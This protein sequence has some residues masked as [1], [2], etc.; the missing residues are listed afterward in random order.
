LIDFGITKR[1]RDPI[2]GE[3]ISFKKN[4]GFM[5]TLRFSSINATR[6]HEQSRRDDLE[7]LGYMLAF[8]L[9]NG[10]LPW[11]GKSSEDSDYSFSSPEVNPKD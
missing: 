4:K 1:F 9:S 5:G 6:G 7:A 11:M 10:R 3:H 2:T 8:F